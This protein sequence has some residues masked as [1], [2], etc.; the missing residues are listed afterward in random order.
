MMIGKTIT[1]EMTGK[2]ITDMII[3]ETTIEVTIGKI[4]E[5]IIIEN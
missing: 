4:I 1:G 3:E 2:I 5:A